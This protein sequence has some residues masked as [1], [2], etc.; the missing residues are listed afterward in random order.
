MIFFQGTTA[1]GLKFLCDFPNNQSLTLSGANVTTNI[2]WTPNNVPGTPMMGAS[3]TSLI[4]AKG[5]MTNASGQVTAI[6]SNPI[7]SATGGAGTGTVTCLSA[8]CTNL[9]GTYSVPGG[10]FVTGNMLVLVWPTTTTAY[11]CT[12]TQN[13]VVTHF[14][15]GNSVATAT[16]MTITNAGTIAGVTVTVNYSC[17]P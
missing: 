8:T 14:G 3:T 10:T 13:G 9:R 6:V 7:T 2:T 12:T 15:I 1:G 16:G 17:T 4:S 11:V 5:L